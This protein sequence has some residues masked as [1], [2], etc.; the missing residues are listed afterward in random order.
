MDLNIAQ[1]MEK[2]PAQ[3]ATGSPNRLF[4]I[5]NLRTGLILLVVLHHVALVYGASLEG[6][7]YVEP[8]FTDPLAFVVLLV[9]ALV[10]QSWFM[11]AFFLVAGY[12]TPGSY[13]RK[14]PGTF[15]KDR[16]FRL[17]IT[18]PLTWNAYP[19]FLG[20]GPMWFVAMLLI[21]NFGYAGWRS[22]TRNRSSSSMSK[23]SPPSYLGIGLFIPLGRDIVRYCK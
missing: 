12:F 11:G 9:F 2:S 19:H 18:T 22:L 16:L 10:N 5:D 8:P 15:L 3:T 21:F 17:G 7:Y 14:G 13:D 6:Y 23:A 20:M 1:P 4:F